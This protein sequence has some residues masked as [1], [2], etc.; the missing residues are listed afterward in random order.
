VASETI[1]DMIHNICTG[2]KMWGMAIFAIPGAE[3]DKINFAFGEFASK[4]VK[5]DGFYLR[6]TNNKP[7]L[8]RAF[9]LFDEEDNL[10]IQIT[11]PS[12]RTWH[13]YGIYT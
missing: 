10:K 6:I 8:R 12:G 11:S 9:K 2:T 5:E 7:E 13:Y 1:A 4:S 3:N